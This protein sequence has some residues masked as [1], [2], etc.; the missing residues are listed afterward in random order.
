MSS[1][2]HIRIASASALPLCLILSACGGDGS[3]GV[4]SIPPPPVTPTPTP[5]PATPTT[6]PSSNI[7]ET[8]LDSPATRNGSY[9][10]IGRLSTIPGNGG[11]ATSRL[12]ATGEFTMS[13]FWYFGRESGDL[14]H[15]TLNGP[16]SV[17]AN[18]QTSLTVNGPFLSWS[19]NPTRSY[20][21]EP[22]GSFC[23]QLLGQHLTSN[24]FS[25]DFTRG[26]S[27]W[28]PSAL[29]WLPSD[30]HTGVQ[31]SLDYDVGN[32]YVAMGDWGWK[33]LA[34]GNAGELLFVEGDRTPSSGIPTTGTATYDARGLN[35]VNGPFSLTANF[36][37]RTMAALIN[38]DYRYQPNGDLMD[39]PLAFGIH[40]SGSAPFSNDGLFNI[41]LTGTANWASSYAIN[42]SLAPAPEPV[43]GSMNGAFF[44]PNAEQVGGTLILNRSSGAQLMQDAFVGQRKP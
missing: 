44:G 38:Q 2:S 19:F 5:T 11:P 27:T 1:R 29:T 32:S 15:Y 41:P 30:N 18:G 12:T 3:Y 16:D 34:T 17:L 8:W 43:T 9:A 13:S 26:V 31:V 35:F 36:D 39:N 4:A 22:S 42:T 40:V 20:A 21:G 6:T 25:Y 37:Q 7:Q 28:Q 24:A 23:C 10:V 33:E 14:P